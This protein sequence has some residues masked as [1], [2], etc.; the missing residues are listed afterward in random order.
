VAHQ[1]L[2]SLGLKLSV[3]GLEDLFKKTCPYCSEDSY[4]ASGAGNW[5]C[6]YCNKN[7]TDVRP[8][9]AGTKNLHVDTSR[10]VMGNKDSENNK[11]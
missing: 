3:K 8:E 11:V 10:A 2:L 6:P 5:V 9:T 1:A 4:S 7:I